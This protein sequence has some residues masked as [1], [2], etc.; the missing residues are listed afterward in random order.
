MNSIWQEAGYERPDPYLDWEFRTRRG[1]GDLWSPIYIRI[2][3][4]Y[5]GYLPG[6]RQL[7]DAVNNGIVEGDEVEP[8]TFTIR[9]SDEE[10]IL[11]DRWIRDLE[12]GGT[13]KDIAMRFFIYRLEALAY[14]NG[15]YNDPAFYQ[16]VFAGPPIDGLHFNDVNAT[17]RGIS[18]PE[19]LITE[20]TVAIGII[21][22]GIAFAHERFCSTPT[23]TRIAAIWLQE[24]ERR[25]DA[26]NSVVFGRLL[27][28]T[29]INASLRNCIREDD[30]YRREGVTDFGQKI[31]NPLASR[32]AH[33]T[34]VLDLAAGHDPADP[35]RGTTRPVLAVQLPS[36]ATIDTSGVTMGSYVLQAARAIMLWAD[37]LHT[38]SAEPL[39]QRPVPLVINFSYGLWAGPKDGTQYVE[40]ALADMVAYRNHFA[41]TRLVLP[42]GNSY[43]ARSTAKMELK[44]KELHSLNWIVLPDDGTANFLEIWIDGDSFTPGK[45]PVEISLSAPD[46]AKRTALRPRLGR[47]D[48]MSIRGEPVAGVYYHVIR[49]DPEKPRVRLFLAINP[50]GRNDDRRDLAPSGGWKVSIR[51]LTK[52]TL[53]ARFYI[54]RD[55]TPFGYPRRGRQSRFD[56]AKAH[57]RDPVTGDYRLQARDCPIIY[58]DTLSSIATCSDKDPDRLV[59]VIGAAEATDNNPP[60]DYTSS[61]P[62]ELRAGPDYSA[63]A[64]EG[65]AHWGR[66]AAGTFSGS[67]VAMR[68]TSVAVP[69]A[70]REIAN[71]LRVGPLPPLKGI[72]VKAQDQPRLG[73][74]IL[75]LPKDPLI[76]R[77][78]PV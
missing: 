12:H 20:S 43:R 9:M 51:N 24:T 71:E 45:C 42:A 6:L 63:F 8:C 67:T 39:V 38:D 33:G 64:D 58:E 26:D 5:E 27:R 25:S 2:V 60:A 30:I 54:Q 11:L 68:G 53:E 1:G 44:G 35:D 49:R 4:T 69:Q 28:G 59:F 48:E 15:E 21:D 40:R 52:K 61:G 7:R 70:T 57:E 75:P 62:T 32:A 47:I 36:V 23:N 16:S 73:K 76:R 3:P 41:P 78:Y 10:R 66:L 37:K 19:L 74:V 56:D 72:P 55:D 46:E 14:L 65:D 77:R 34:H 22:D 50:T 18:F 31:Y 17:P 29:D 13:A